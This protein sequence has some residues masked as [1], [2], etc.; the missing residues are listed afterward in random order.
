MYISC[1]IEDYRKKHGTNPSSLE[2][3]KMWT[4]SGAWEASI[5]HIC[6]SEKDK[7]RAWFSCPADPQ[8]PYLFGSRAGGKACELQC[9]NHKGWRHFIDFSGRWLRPSSQPMREKDWEEYQRLKKELRAKGDLKKL[10]EYEQSM[11]ER[12]ELTEFKNLL[13]SA[14]LE[15]TGDQTEALIAMMR[16]TREA[17]LTAEEDEELYKLSTTLPEERKMTMQEYKLRWREACNARYLEGAKNI[18]TADQIKMFEQYLNRQ[19]AMAESDAEHKPALQPESNDQA[20]VKLGKIDTVLPSPI[21]MSASKTTRTTWGD[22]EHGSVIAASN[23]VN[24]T[25]RVSAKM[26]SGWGCGVTFY[27]DSAAKNS[28]HSINA[29]GAKQV[30]VRVNAPAGAKLRLGLLESGA[31]IAGDYSY[32]GVEGADGEAF[33]HGGITT[34]EGRQTYTIPLSEMKLLGGYGNQKG[35][36]TID[37]QAMK[38][39][40]ILIPG[41]EPDVNF[42]VEWVRLE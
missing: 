40:E 9:L 8:S 19:L 18:L 13:D 41:G 39:V 36:R 35:N 29:S 14:G 38:A 26:G 4:C 5:D 17:K 11:G 30:V 1:A 2:E 37:V 27:P 42:E 21:V 6:T 3:L 24:G 20:P 34:T 25:L 12:L 31:D 7:V 15:L 16:H 33:R 32:V 22:N 28:D 10:E 23:T